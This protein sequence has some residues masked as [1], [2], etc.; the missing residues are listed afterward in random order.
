VREDVTEQVEQMKKDWDEKKRK[1]AGERK[2]KTPT[3]T[4]VEAAH[5]H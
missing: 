2:Q 4:V 1:M 3:H 5:S